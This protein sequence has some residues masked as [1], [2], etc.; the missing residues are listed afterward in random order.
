M[1]E[2]ELKLQGMIDKV[3]SQ[4]RV[5]EERRSEAERQIE[6]LDSRLAAYQ[7]TLKDYWE[8]IDKTEMSQPNLL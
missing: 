2:F 6:I 7:I 4:R 1:D 3:F 5:W 8:S